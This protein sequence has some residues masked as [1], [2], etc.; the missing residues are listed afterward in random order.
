VQAQQGNA[1]EQLLD[2]REGEQGQRDQWPDGQPYPSL[3]VLRLIAPLR[4]SSPRGA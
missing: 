3:L 2:E 1:L 4:T